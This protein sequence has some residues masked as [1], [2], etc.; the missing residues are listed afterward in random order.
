MSWVGVSAATIARAV[1]RGDASASEVVDQHLRHIAGND[2]TIGAFRVVRTVNALAEAEIV[3]DLPDLSGLALA[4][5]PIAIKEN[6]AVAGER[7]CL[8]SAATLRDSAEKD[9]EVVRRLRGAGAVVVGLTRMPELGLFGTTDD[10]DVVTRNPWRLDRTAGGSSG[11]SAAAVASGMVPIALGNDGLGSIRIPAACCGL[12]GLKPGRG[13]VPAGLSE[14]DWFGLIANG[15]L[16]STVEDSAIGFAVL[17]GRTPGPLAEPGRLRLA[18]SLRSPVAGV[19][20]DT[21]AKQAVARAVRAL[22]GAG[23]S[24]QRAELYYPQTLGLGTIAT[25]FAAAAR[26]AEPF[27]LE[28]LQRRTRRHVL[29]GRRAER[30]VREA[31]RQRW[32]DRVLGWFDSGGHDLLVTPMLAGAPPRAE[33]W[34]RRGWRGN[35]LGSLRYAPYAAPWNVAGLP[36]IAVPAGTRRD[37]LP[38]AVQI[39]GPPGSEEL[40]L[41]VAGQ[42]EQAAP[43]RTHAAG[44]PRIDEPAARAS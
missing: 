13:V 32:R 36:A 29:L 3:D 37:G 16:A 18:V 26:D 2:G 27:D 6:V 41:A 21:D 11:G 42:L 4:G 25:W 24:A 28:E 39:V 40:L 9:H 33:M 30:F 8:G 12:V 23:H 44:W 38:A 5:V 1:R 43:W 19:V 10:E 17:A 7:T 20:P 34:S 22:V 14:H 31:D 15:V 35:L